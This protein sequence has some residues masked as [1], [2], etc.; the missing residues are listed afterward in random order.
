MDIFLNQLITFYSNNATNLHRLT[1]HSTT[2]WPTKWRS[3]C[4]HRYMTSLHPMYRCTCYSWNSVLRRFVWTFISCVQVFFMH[5]A[6]CKV[7]IKQRF[8]CL[9]LR[10]DAS[11]VH[12]CVSTAACKTNNIDIKTSLESCVLIMAA[13]RSRCCGHYVF[14]LWFL[15]SSFFSFFPRLISAVAYWMSAILAHM[16]W[17]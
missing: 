4:D 14:A 5:A 8:W 9:R 12:S 3:H 7:A 2:C 10:S 16:V 17:P 1:T 15:L 6:D 11:W 13:L